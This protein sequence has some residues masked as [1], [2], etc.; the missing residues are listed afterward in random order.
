MRVGSDLLASVRRW[1]SKAWDNRVLAPR[2]YFVTDVGRPNVMVAYLPS[3][4]YDALPRTKNGF[5][6]WTADMLPPS[7]FGTP[8]YRLPS[9]LDKRDYEAEWRK[10]GR[11]V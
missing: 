6:P 11:R 1:W 8:V 3:A 9:Y 7:V 4:E 5:S 10:G 2:A